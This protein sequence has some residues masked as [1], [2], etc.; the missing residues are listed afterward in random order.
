MESNS[1]GLVVLAMANGK[2]NVRMQA[3]A[4][5]CIQ[6]IAKYALVH[7]H[8]WDLF[9]GKYFLYWIK[10]QMCWVAK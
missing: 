9:D 3:L 7:L 5:P 4:S 8:H 1:R 2:C 10:L 6:I